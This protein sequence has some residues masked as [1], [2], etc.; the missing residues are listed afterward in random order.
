M[1]IYRRWN[2]HGPQLAIQIWR[3]TFGR[4]YDIEID[5]ARWFFGFLKCR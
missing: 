2:N 1:K 5:R 3:I 4:A